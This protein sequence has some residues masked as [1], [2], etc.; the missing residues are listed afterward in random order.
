MII[1]GKA[2]QV[3]HYNSGGKVKASCNSRWNHLNGP[4]EIFWLI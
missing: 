1:V 4:A 3:G 2:R